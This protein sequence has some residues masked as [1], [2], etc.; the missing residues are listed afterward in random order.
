MTQ[1][2]DKLQAMAH[3]NGYQLEILKRF[4]NIESWKWPEYA[5]RFGSVFF[6]FRH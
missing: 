5:L 3:T 2:I 6:N 1:H 4:I